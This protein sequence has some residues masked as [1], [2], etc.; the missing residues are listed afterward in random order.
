MLTKLKVF[1]LSDKGNRN[2][3]HHQDQKG[4]WYTLIVPSICNQQIV[5]KAAQKQ[6]DEE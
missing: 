5:L 1:S 4:M 6:F 2:N 3:I